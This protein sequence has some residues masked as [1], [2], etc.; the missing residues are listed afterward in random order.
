[1]A[2]VKFA[3]PSRLVGIVYSV[4]PLSLWIVQREAIFDP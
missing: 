1:M 3:P 2:M 4:D